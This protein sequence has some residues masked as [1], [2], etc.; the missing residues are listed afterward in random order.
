MSRI[1]TVQQTIDIIRAAFQPLQCI[2]HSEDAGSVVSFAV[3]DHGPMELTRLQ[4]FYS[5]QLEAI[6]MD[7]IAS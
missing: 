3:S 4:F 1:L 5:T 7:A 6:L 2:V